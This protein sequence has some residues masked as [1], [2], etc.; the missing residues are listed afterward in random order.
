M[1]KLR[2]I[3]KWPGGKAKLLPRIKKLLPKASTFIE[4]FMGSGFLSLHL[5]YEQ[6][7]LNDSNPHLIKFFQDLLEYNSE[8][9]ELAKALFVKDNNTEAKYLDFREQFNNMPPGLLRSAL[10]LYLNRHGY[11]GLCRFNKS[12]GYNVPFGRYSST[13]FPEHELEAFIAKKS[14]IKLFNLDF[15]HF[16]SNK[17]FPI[18][19]VIYCDPPYVPL[20]KSSSFTSYDGNVF[21]FAEQEQLVNLINN[22]K[23]CLPTL[24]SN[25]YTQQTKML[26][27]EA[28]ISTFYVP[29]YISCKG[30]TRKQV[31]ELLALYE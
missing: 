7:L 14:R 23:P 16:L 17:S 25:H 3:F 18:D 15:K 10:F 19:S 12:G 1:H 31:K 13:Y 30:N 22:L 6:Y 11:N 20:N 2:A 8:L 9:V 27:K 28:E 24:I 26:Y 5:E 29:R 21:S 4:P